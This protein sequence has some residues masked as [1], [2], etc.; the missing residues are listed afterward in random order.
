MPASLAK[1]PGMLVAA[2]ATLALLAWGLWPQPVPVETVAARR[3]PLTVTIEEEGMTRVI[4]RFVITAPVAGVA[5]RIT[6]KAGDAI[7]RGQTL[8][9]LKPPESRILDPRSQ[10]EAEARVAAAKAS[11]ESARHQADSAAATAQFQR[12]EIKRLKPLAD[13]GV[14]S[15]EA[16]DRAE[17]QSRT[18]DAALSAAQ[19]AVDVS[20]YELEAAQTAL[21]YAAGTAK[22]SPEDYVAVRSPIDGRVLKVLHEWEGPV[23]T[24]DTLLEVGD[25]TRLEVAVD[26][27]SADAVKINPGM[28][29]RFERWGGSEP[30]EGVVRT[31]EPMGFTKISALGVEEQRVW[32]IADFTSPPALWQRLGDGY[33]VDAHFVLW[34]GDDVLQVPASSLFRYEDGWALFVD[35]DGRARRRAVTVGERSALA[36]QILEGVT[37]G[38]HVID[39]PSDKVDDGVR[40]ARQG[41]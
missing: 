5:G 22:V 34:H 7:E 15:H 29:V 21:R 11:L 33:R 20:R 40:V 17:M 24:G 2:V 3:A 23:N 36:A 38:T 12:L 10:A 16:L 13:K 8:V 4:D 9:S 28:P 19:H 35:D 30:L 27:L 26:V 6:L 39:H 1:Y 18:A 37:P 31:V 14:I 41:T 25:P 32:I